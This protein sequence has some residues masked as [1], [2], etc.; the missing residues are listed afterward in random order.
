ML[1]S[2]VLISVASSIGLGGLFLFLARNWL[3]ERLRLSIKHE[4]DEKLEQL[5]AQLLAQNS[6]TIETQKAQFAK[7][8]EEL[9]GVLQREIEEYKVATTS[10]AGSY[11]II[12]T[13]LDDVASSCVGLHE[14]YIERL[15]PSDESTLA[16]CI[17]ARSKAKK[18]L[19]QVSLTIGEKLTERV[20]GFLEDYWTEIEAFRE[21]IRIKKARS[22]IAQLTE[23]DRGYDFNLASET[24]RGN[25]RYLLQLWD[26][27]K[28]D[29]RK[30]QQVELSNIALEGMLRDKAAQPP[31]P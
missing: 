1:M 19:A 13:A 17:S 25:I 12:W 10:K 18:V 28:E 9:K 11:V 21:C 23:H 3:I 29:L 20:E 6:S 22:E 8:L 14:R 4:Y 2:E 27:I 16:L 31:S 30:G 5:K 26:A 7:E 24:T 15:K